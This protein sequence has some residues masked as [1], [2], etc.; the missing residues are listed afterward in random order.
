MKQQLKRIGFVTCVRLGLSCLEEIYRMNGNVELLITLKDTE[1]VGKSGRVYLDQ[2]AL[3]HNVPLIKVKNIN[4]NEVIQ[5]VYEKRLDWLFIIGWSQ[6]A[7][8]NILNAPIKGCIGMHPTLLPEGR[9]RASIPWAIL[10]ELP[11]TGVTMF[12]LNEGMDTGDIIDQKIIPLSKNITASE[13]YQEVEKT[14]ITI[15]AHNWNSIINDTVKWKK[16]DETRATIW[17]GRTPNDGRITELMNVRDALKLIRAVTHPYPGAF[18]DVDGKKWRIW[19]ARKSEKKTIF[20]LKDGYI[21][22][23]E[24]ELDNRSEV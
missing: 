19:S 7:K 14:H 5:A 22:P 21:E 24:F 11:Q 2:F 13:L 17:P 18:M 9:G 16:Q 10:K 1:A 8:R 6:I 23:L 4:D 3:E 15:L 20:K 12:K